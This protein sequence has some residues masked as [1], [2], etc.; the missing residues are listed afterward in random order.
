LFTRRKTE[1]YGF[2]TIETIETAHQR[3]DYQQEEL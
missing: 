2:E 1:P 3:C